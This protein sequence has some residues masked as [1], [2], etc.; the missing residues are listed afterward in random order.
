MGDQ[1][2][3]AVATS[4]RR[5]VVGAPHDDA[6]ATNAGSVNV[7]DVDS[8]FPWVP[9]AALKNP[10][11][12][13]G[14]NFGNAVAIADDRVVVGASGAGTSGAGAA[15]LYDLST[16]KPD[17]P[18]AVLHNPSPSAGGAFGR[19]VAISGTRVVIGTQLSGKAYVYDFASVTPAQPV[20]TLLDPAPGAGNNFSKAVAIEGT[21]VALG[22]PGDGGVEGTAGSVHIF[23]TSWGLLQAT[24]FNAA[25]TSGSGPF[26][27]G[28]GYWIGQ[29]AVTLDGV[30]AAE[31]R[32]GDRDRPETWMQATV[33]GPA[34][35]YFSYRVKD[36]SNAS[37]LTAGFFLDSTL[38]S[39]H[40]GFYNSD[41]GW[42]EFLAVIPPG[43]QTVRWRLQGSSSVRAYVDQVWTSTDARPRITDASNRTA[44][45]ATLFHWVVPVAS[46]SP[47]ILVASDLPRGLTV[48]G[49]AHVIAGTPSEAGTFETTLT[50]VN[51]SGRHI[52]KVPFTVEPGI[53][54]IPEAVDA[55]ALVFTQPDAG[56]AWIGAVGMGHDGSDCARCSGAYVLEGN[57]SL[58]TTLK[59]PGT[60]TFWY[61]SEASLVDPRDRSY[62]NLY[63]GISPLSLSATL[64]L[65]DTSWTKA[66]VP[67]PA[68]SQS[69]SWRAFRSLI[70]FQHF[71]YLDEIAFVPSMVPPQSTFAAWQEAWN[72]VGQPAATDTD[73]DGLTLVM[74]Y[75]LG[76]SPSLPDAGL[77]P[78]VSVLDGFLTLNVIKAPSP[79]DLL[80]FVQTSKD[81]APNSWTTGL[82][83]ILEEDGTH[84]LARCK[85]PVSEQPVSYL[86]VRVLVAP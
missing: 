42:R 49:E 23:V 21:T 62:I 82:V 18:I 53:T 46:T 50:A 4:G 61:R 74:E 84:L 40:T 75:A 32:L 41:T 48:D 33:P 66:T 5:V 45:Y 65:V 55:P 52:A 30:D 20:A 17:L 13:E 68:G 80:Y 35:L 70:P 19:S 27:S 63:V 59:G 37:S 10:S 24:D 12:T 6:G 79:T 54:A 34:T 73:G 31:G 71:V 38:I 72:V 67:I 22:S 69:I 16:S 81:L 57:Y 44:A 76:G 36:F 86:R 78:A 29:S 7:Y 77:L 8:A 28:P 15:F 2:G 11:P 85:K 60:L 39:P 51:S 25:W 9:V 14:A 1:F 3:A 26:L 64:G 43:G 83:D 47:V 58:S 56:T